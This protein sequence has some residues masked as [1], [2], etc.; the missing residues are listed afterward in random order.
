MLCRALEAGAAVLTANNRLARVLLTEYAGRQQAAGR[1]TW[2]S[3]EILPWSRWARRCWE[4][5]FYSGAS[6]PSGPRQVLL[7]PHQ[8]RVV[9]EQVIAESPAGANLLLTSA[10]AHQ[11]AQAWELLHAWRL[12]VS[13]PA[14]ET[15]K[16]GKTFLQ[17]AAA[18]ESR[19]ARQG[20]LNQARLVD[21]VAERI[22]SGAVAFPAKVLLIGFDEFTPQQEGLWQALRGA[23]CRLE[24]IQPPSA[25]AA[26]ALVGLDSVEEEILTAA[27]WARRAL[28]GGASGNIGIVVRGLSGLRAKVERIFADILNPGGLL[29]GSPER[30]PA[31]HISIGAPL[32]EYPVVQ[33]A[34]L[35]LEM[36]PETLALEKAASLL[37]SPFL[38]G[39]QSERTRRAVVYT[40]LAKLGGIDVEIEALGRAA[41]KNGCPALAASLSQWC[42]LR[43]AA[44]RRQR[45]SQWSE[46]FSLALSALGWPG[47]RGLNSAEFQTVQKVSELL[48]QLAGLNF[49]LPEIG[50]QE[51]AA[52]LRKLTSETQFQP[53][54]A[55]EPI[56]ILG[57]LEASGM[58][59][60]HLW[61]AGLH[62]DAWPPAPSPNP[63]LPARL[64]RSHGLPHASAQREL[65]FARAATNRLL[66]SAPQIVVSYPKRDEDRDLG[67][68]PLLAALQQ[69]SSADLALSDRNSFAERIRGQTELETLID[70]TA[71]PF[72]L[73]S[74]TRGGSDV[75]RLQSACPFRAF[76]ELRLGA[77][78]PEAA[79]PGLPAKDRGILMHSA[80]QSLW[81]QLGSQANL[82]SP[83]EEELKEQIGAAV[84]FAMTKNPPRR[85][86]PARHW[87]LERARLQKLLGEWLE[88]EKQRKRFTVIE[89]E[90]KRAIEFAGLQLELRIDRIDQLEDGRQ[91]FIDYKSGLTAISKWGG[92]R[93]DEPQLPLY[94]VT[95]EQQP[96]AIAFAQVHKG[97]LKFKGMAEEEGLLPGVP[98]K[99]NL[100]SQIPEWK[101]NL[102]RLGREYRAGRAVVDPKDP[103]VTCEQCGLQALCRIYEQRE[104][105]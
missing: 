47:E 96:A 27:R 75:F 15:T 25:P 57:I 64:Q 17:W 76:A 14:W 50:W 23:G 90:K 63:F 74:P 1:K 8:E 87:S 62:D 2:C 51:A 29:P 19:C 3:P 65:A 99:T 95:H 84:D 72:G 85:R 92:E 49:T 73:E 45:A 36:G 68:S 94:C 66:A 100:S 5:C 9:W 58:C 24:E 16:D 56:Q 98:A 101:E 6:G 21:S 67:P 93:P 11:A 52:R 103:S 26:A 104:E 43:S 48:S 22:R 18:F 102:E 28:E 4:D 54:G 12:P 55:G 38:R 13:D 34:L 60:D 42:G 35:I 71:P 79:E 30:P 80:L 20:W 7:D 37:R 40:E 86:L 82:C 69:K 89:R 41:S 31:F 39:S 70:D 46:T 53:E 32:V 33:A 10:T 81:L 77:S 88:I 105:A 91:I 44:R 97:E 78:K 61:I 59:F 83:A